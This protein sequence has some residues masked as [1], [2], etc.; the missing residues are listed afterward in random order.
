M[1]S[2]VMHFWKKVCIWVQIHTP[3]ELHSN[4]SEAQ[5][6]CDWWMKKV[7]YTKECIVSDV[8]S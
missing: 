2:H 4:D 7:M 1:N 6:E 3:E 5:R 8:A